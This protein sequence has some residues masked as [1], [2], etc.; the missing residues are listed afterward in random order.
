MS[1]GDISEWILGAYYDAVTKNDH[2]FGVA[3]H[4]IFLVNKRT[5]AA[6]PI[7]WSSKKI[8][9]DVSSSLAAETLG[10]V[11]LICVLYFIKDKS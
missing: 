1:L 3:G 4:V 10:L 9:R 5:H 7:T 8:E 2:A 11:K 6:S